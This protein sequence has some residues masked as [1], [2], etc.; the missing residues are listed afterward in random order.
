M[1]GNEQSQ[2]FAQTPKTSFLFLSPLA[3]MIAKTPKIRF[4]IKNLLVS[5]AREIPR[6]TDKKQAVNKATSLPKRTVSKIEVKGTKSGYRTTS[7]RVLVF[8]N[9]INSDILEKRRVNTTIVT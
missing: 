3:K 1:T 9:K 5:T 8:F 4:T 7:R 6:S 2:T